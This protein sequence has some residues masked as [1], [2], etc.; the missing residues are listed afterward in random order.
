MVGRALLDTISP[1]RRPAGQPRCARVRGLSSPGIDAGTLE[2]R[3]FLCGAEDPSA[4]WRAPGALNWLCP[5]WRPAL[6]NRRSLDQRPQSSV[7]HTREAITAGLG[8]A[9]EDRRKRASFWT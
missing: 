5:F 6:P 7:S 2:G 8:Y 1:S 3:W 9:P 4:G